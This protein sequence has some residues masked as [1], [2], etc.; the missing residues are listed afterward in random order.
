VRIA[1]AVEDQQRLAVPG[2]IPSRVLAQIAQR[3]W[4]GDGDDTAMQRGA[5]HT[6]QFRRADLPVGLSATGQRLAERSE[7]VLVGG[8][9]KEPLDPAG[10]AFEQGAHSGEPADPQ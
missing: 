2:P 7:I 6:R 8:L 10:I 5:G 9:E 1:D 3:P 4:T